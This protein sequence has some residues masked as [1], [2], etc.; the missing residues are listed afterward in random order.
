[1]T[2]PTPTKPANSGAKWHTDSDKCG[3]TRR[4]TSEEY[5][6]LIEHYG[7]AYIARNASR[8]ESSGTGWIAHPTCHRCYYEG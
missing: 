4:L 3:G 1:M 7:A 2:Q 6:A 8:E 5:A